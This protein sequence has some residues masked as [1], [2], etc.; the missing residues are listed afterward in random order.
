MVAASSS[1]TESVCRRVTSTDVAA[2]VKVTALPVEGLK[3]IAVIGSVK[4]KT[5]RPAGVSQSETVTCAFPPPPVVWFFVPLQ[6]ASD[7]AVAISKRTRQCLELMQAPH[8]VSYA[9]NKTARMARDPE[10]HSTPER[11]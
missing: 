6:D 9:A 8:F 11:R 7:S 5:L 3:V 10:K 2:G 4:L 1:R